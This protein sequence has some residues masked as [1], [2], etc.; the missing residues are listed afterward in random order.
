MPR[1]KKI[2]KDKTGYRQMSLFEVIAK[3][4]EAKTQVVAMLKMR[5]TERKQ[6]RGIVAVPPGSL[7][8]MIVGE[9]Q[10]KTDIPLEIPFFT[11]LHW[12]ASTLLK[13]GIVVNFSDDMPDIKPDIWTV[14]LSKSGRSKSFTQDMI[15]PVLGSDDIQFPAGVASAARWI[16]ELQI[17]NNSIWVKDEFGA[18]LQ[19]LMVMPHMQEIREYLLNMY[20]NRPIS[21]ST[22]ECDIVVQNPALVIYGLS[23]LESFPEQVSSENLICGFAQRFNYVIAHDDPDRK[24]IDYPIYNLNRAQWREEW[25][26]LNSEIKHQKYIAR[27][28]AIEAYKTAF[29]TLWRSEVDGSFYRRLLWGA[30]KYALIYHVLRGQGAQQ[31]LTPE[32]YGWAGRVLYLHIQDMMDILDRQGYGEFERKLQAAENFHEKCMREGKDFTVR[33]LISGVKSIKN[34][35]EA[36]AILSVIMTTSPAK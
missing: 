27:N 23:Q 12:V 19:N 13:R 15:A 29:K 22:K 36:K 5:K 4:D 35:T 18:F 9:F 25:D 14:C 24:M 33:N 11:L 7:A 1:K 34:A 8:E 31:E 6:W 20:G 32:D 16:Q 10:A 2:Q 21:R 17:H 3:N 26:R 28:R 30:H